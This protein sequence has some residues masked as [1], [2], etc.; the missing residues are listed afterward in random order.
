[1]S[2]NA[3]LITVTN[4]SKEHAKQFNV[5]LNMEIYLNIFKTKEQNEVSLQNF[6]FVHY[7]KF[8]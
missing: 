8:K 2:E 1:M 7:K 3:T 4:M 6:S 5:G